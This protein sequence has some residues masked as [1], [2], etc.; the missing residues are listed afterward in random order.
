[1]G[2][3]FE[4][5]EKVFYP[6]HGVAIVE[7]IER[8]FWEGEEREIYLLKVVSANSFTIMVPIDNC[9]VVGMR[10]LCNENEINSVVQFLE[11]PNIKIYKDWKGRYK[12]NQDKMKTGGLREVAEVLKN[13]HYISGTK[14]LSFREKKMYEK[15]KMLIVSE[16]SHVKGI[17]EQE[18][19]EIIEI[20]LQKSTSATI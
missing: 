3:R 12:H 1:M 16:I 7:K 9:E 18:A 6:Y 2:Y 15:A 17:S 10:P 13:L 11:E 4:I 14:S 19:E 8:K 20:A 5:G